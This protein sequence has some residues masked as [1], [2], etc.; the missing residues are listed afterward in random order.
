MK[1]RHQQVMDKANVT[2]VAQPL[3]K[4]KTL[5]HHF[6]NIVK[7]Q[8]IRVVSREDQLLVDA[9]L[10][11]WMSECLRPFKIVEDSGFV[12][13]CA[14]L[15]QLRSRYE[16][17]SRNK[18]RNQMMKLAECVMK[19]LKESINMEVDYYSITTDIWSS[20]VMQSFIAVTL[21]YLTEEFNMKIFVIEVS[22]LKGNHTGAFIAECLG[23]TLSKF[24]LQTHKLVLLLRDNASNGI[25]ACKDMTV[26]HFG[27]IGHSLHLVVRPFLLEK[28]S[29]AHQN[30]EED[31]EENGDNE[32][33]DDVA[34]FELI[35]GKDNISEEIVE[36][37][38]K[39]VSKFR[40]V[41]KYIKHSPKAKEKIEHFDHVVKSNNRDTINILLNVRTRWNSALDMLTSMLKLRKGIQ[42]F[43]HYLKTVDGRKEFNYKKLPDLSEQDWVL[44]EGICLVLQPFKNVT[45]ILSGSKYPTF[46]QALPY[47]RRLKMFLVNAQEG[48]FTN[49]TDIMPI[50]EFVAKYCDEEFFQNIICDLKACCCILLEKF[51]FYGSHF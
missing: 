31:V 37:V 26:S 25:K 38:C 20:H 6:S 19:K 44:I 12:E 17:P 50:K 3:K 41:A 16:L 49:E 14:F 22:L 30:E 10:V 48:L 24:N 33:D 7:E 28:K 4:Q 27:C 29:K 32:D 34:E 51:K 11:K 15:N 36:C 8:N 43:A 40:K 23:N 35:E 9:L 5:E 45:A 1:K 39:M 46:S 2:D 13:F 18:H 21:H 42:S 47:L